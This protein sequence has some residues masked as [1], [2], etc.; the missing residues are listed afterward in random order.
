M[1]VLDAQSSGCG[2]PPLPFQKARVGESDSE[3][4]RL[5]ADEPWPSRLCSQAVV[6]RKAQL[7][8]RFR[9]G[10]GIQRMSIAFDDMVSE[11][12]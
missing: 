7:Y 12:P 10:G 8:L 3:R 2:T 9:P 4:K 1:V 11:L 6:F 5:Q